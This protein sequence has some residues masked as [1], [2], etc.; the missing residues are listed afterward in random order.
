MNKLKKL[1]KALLISGLSLFL[2]GLVSLLSCYFIFGGE[3]ITESLYSKEPSLQLLYDRGEYKKVNLEELSEK[4]LILYKMLNAVDITDNYDTIKAK[5]ETYSTY[6]IS[7]E[8]HEII[9]GQ[10]TGVQKDKVKMDLLVDNT[11]GKTLQTTYINNE[12]NPV[13]ALTYNDGERYTFL[14][15]GDKTYYDGG[16][17]YA[18]GEDY[19]IEPT[20]VAFIQALHPK[21]R[22]GIYFDR[23]NEFG[24]PLPMQLFMNDYRV[25]QVLIFE[26]NNWNIVAE[27]EYLGMNCLVLEA[28]LSHSIEMETTKLDLVVDKNTGIVL[29]KNSYDANNKLLSSEK[30]T[31][32]KVNEPI[33]PSAFVFDLTGYTDGYAEEKAKDLQ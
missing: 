5:Y 20:E 23:L 9:E 6:E 7:S 21:D 8:T 14:H 17:Y 28:N 24:Q 27:K 1:K 26:Y 11:L 30:A 12:P 13:L 16:T 25:I 18:M 10:P 32:F 3:P 19:R 22:G 31:E 33:D 2:L 29:E 4:D 15:P